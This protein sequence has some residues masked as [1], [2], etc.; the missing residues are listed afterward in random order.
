MSQVTKNATTSQPEVL[1]LR[2]P[3][4]T[5]SRLE[6]DMERM[7][8]DFW[9]RPFLGLWDSDRWWPGRTLGLQMP[10]VDVYEEKDDVV[11]KAEIPGLS[12]EEIEVMLTDSTLTIKGEKKKEEETKEKNYYCSERS[13][14]SFSR[15]LE[16]PA[17]VKTDQAKASFKD[18][19][20]EIRLP[21][22]EEAKKKAVKV[23]VN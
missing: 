17:E 8:N 7:F 4:G 12:K 3:F 20:L 1:A 9:R 11:V 6:Q 16:L 5:L 2:T 23:K 14:G 21:K 10:A 18:G 22:T 15:H 13:S 19:I